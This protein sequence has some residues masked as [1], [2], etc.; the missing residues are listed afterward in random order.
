MTDLAPNQ[1]VTSRE[2]LEIREKSWRRRTAVVSLAAETLDDIPQNRR[3]QALKAFGRL[4]ER[5]EPGPAVERLARRY[6]AVHVLATAGVAAEHYE[7]ATFWPKLIDILRIEPDPNF[8]RTW[9]E[10]FLD[11]LRTL[12]LPTFEADGDAGTRFVGRILLHSGMP[13]YCLDDFFKLISWRRS[14]TP[15]L[16]PEAFVSWAA[17]RAA[18]RGISNV[19]MPV[20]RFVRFGDEFAVD[21]ADRSFE[22]LDALVA[23]T[24][25]DD[26]FLP[27]RYVEEARK[28]HEGRAIEQ[29][30]RVGSMG[31]VSIDIRPRLVLDPFGQGLILRLPPVGDAPDGRAVWVVT[32]GDDS[33]R[34]ATE[35]LWPGSTEPA[36]QTDVAISTPVRNAS[37]A[38]AGH[39]DLQLSMIV[40]DDLDPLM[41]FGDDGEL[42]ASGLPL[43][44]SLAWI[45]FPGDPDALEVTGDLHVNAE[46]PLPPA[47]S[48]FCLLQ[49]DLT[50]VTALSVGASAR[51]VRK[52]ES[53]QID[54]PSPI[55]G[56][57]TSTALPVY[58]DLPD[59]RI[60]GSLEAADWDVTLHDDG[61]GEVIARHRVSEAEG[62]NRLWQSIP[63]P[64]VGS[65]TVRVRGPWGRGATRTFTVVEG[66]AVTFSPGW[67]RF[68]PH[69]LRQC[70]A[71]LR[72]AEGV[73]LS[74][75]YI[76]FDE[77]KQDH[78]LRAGAPSCYR[79]LV[80]TPPHMTVAYQ[81]PHFALSRSV[82]PM[83][84]VRE[85][86]QESPGEVLLDVGAGAEPVL[87][88]IA[89]NRSVQTLSVRSG[90]AGIYRFN[91]AEIVDTLRDH[92]QVS[93]ALSEDGE[94][95]VATLR[96][97]TLFTGIE[98]DGD[99]LA[100]RDCV[101]IDGLAMYLFATRAPWREPA[102]VPVVDGR[103]PLPAWLIDAGPIRLMARIEDPWV[104]LPVPDWP[105]PGKSRLVD[106]DGWVTDGDSEEVAVS[107]FL[108]GDVSDPVDVI[109]F[110]RLWTVRALLP[111]LS[112]GDR[113]AE[114]A[115]A[116]DTEIYANPAA[117][118]AALT[119][120]EAPSE[121]IPSLMIRSGLAWANLAD[122]HETTAP[123]W[124]KR[125]ALP[126]A[127]LSAADSVWSEEEIE[128]A[129]NVCGDAV[130]GLLD[131]ADPYA[132]AGCIDDSAE[133]LDQNPALR[134][135]YIQAGRLIPQGLLSAESR[136]L[137]AMDLVAKRRDPGLEWLMRNTRSV[138]REGERLIRMIGD[139]RTQRAF[140][141]RRHHSRTDG[142][143]VVPAI[144]IALA[145]GARHAARGHVE[146]A[147][148]MLREQRPWADLAE[149]VP[150]LVT[151]DLIIAELTVG[152]RGEAFE[153]E[154]VE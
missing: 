97:R 130:N 73:D 113:I 114:V 57:R 7:R 100:L 34:V 142:W 146:A 143:Q 58:A 19:D 79:T 68:V 12:G 154:F 6:P 24:G 35:S 85:D 121:A 22:L 137:S 98:L 91:L 13:T 117:A 96:P 108:A 139:N 62:P 40:V 150:Q 27:A 38:L 56:V 123:P 72:A 77:R 93:L 39:E 33:R 106:A 122:A 76:E 53:A 152:R 5:S 11:N 131:G 30:A 4:Y 129:I 47:W 144:S 20:Q 25:Y 126:A 55:H 105:G 86:V 43:P 102:C 70:V 104:P 78:V 81:A 54:L 82:R 28:L 133:L 71:H 84:L 9:G 65:F 80:V 32:L 132:R 21:V 23:G 51:T 120:S 135:Q 48:G 29:V 3:E 89:N 90:R 1:K 88:V 95:V 153:Q 115:E 50:E 127:L 147:R 16:T 101:A 66:L 116:I 83:A 134:E 141:A 49:V 15:G 37:V 26:V 140:D 10:A 125:G 118:L 145:L 94:L 119:G 8:Q 67:R 42:I 107:K 64:L 59:I 110:V 138:L 151:I 149:V 44:G 103:V 124:T 41:A 52:F 92:P 46:S 87:H 36:P 31:S 74:R 60:P 69:G 148:W 99:H 75:T 14:R 109:D 18:G 136:V 112:L 2:L 17:A 45:L 63:R 111:A 61:S 128:G